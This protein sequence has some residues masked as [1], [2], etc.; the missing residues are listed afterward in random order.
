MFPEGDTCS[1]KVKHECLVPKNCQKMSFSIVV[2]AHITPKTN[3]YFPEI[4]RHQPLP[5]YFICMYIKCTCYA[6]SKPIFSEIY[7]HQALPKY[8]NFMCIE[9]TYC[10]KVKTIFSEMFRHQQLP[11]DFIFTWIQCTCFPSHKQHSLDNFGTKSC[12]NIPF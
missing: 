11:K 4:F 5:K 10:S 9:C 8:S 1:Q 2:S 7:R 3:R 6:Q 12:R